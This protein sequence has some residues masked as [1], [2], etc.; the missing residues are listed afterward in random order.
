MNDMRNLDL[1]RKCIE[2]INLTCKKVPIKNRGVAV[3]Q[4]ASLFQYFAHKLA[5]DGCLKTKPWVNEWA[6][7]GKI[8]IESLA[9]GCAMIVLASKQEEMD[10]SWFDLTL[11]TATR[12]SVFDARNK[13]Y[14]KAVEDGVLNML[15]CQTIDAIEMDIAASEP[16][17]PLKREAAGFRFFTP[18]KYKEAYETIGKLCQEF[19]WQRLARSRVEKLFAL[20]TAWDSHQFSNEDLR[21][22]AIALVAIVARDAKQGLNMKRVAEVSGCARE[23]V[24]IGSWVN[25]VIDSL[26]TLELMNDC[27][28]YE[29]Y[30]IN[31]SQLG[32]GH[33]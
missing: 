26:R 27:Y 2:L 4:S 8:C 13:I 14:E 30:K 5:H 23:A 25:V 19:K 9:V 18:S 20:I 21:G 32:F 7:E 24:E 15:G 28:F 33:E 11:T 1:V 22:L 29:P 3:Q 17:K 6:C 10:L 12:D 16:F 31:G